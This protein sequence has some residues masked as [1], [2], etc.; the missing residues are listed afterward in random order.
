MSHPY[1]RGLCRICYNRFY[2]R[3]AKKS[4]DYPDQLLILDH[5]KFKVFYQSKIGYIIHSQFFDTTHLSR[6]NT[7]EQVLLDQLH[8]Q[9]LI[10]LHNTALELEYT[11]I[12]QEDHDNPA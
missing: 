5:P 8:R 6:P 3:K 10:N 11:L 1:A 9:I 7:L 12:T 2:R 4:I